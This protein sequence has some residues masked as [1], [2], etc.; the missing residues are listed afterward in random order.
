MSSETIV[1][2][3]TCWPDFT[4]D[5]LIE[6]LKEYEKRDRRFGAIKE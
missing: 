2:T 1:F 3:N 6:C 5:K 4:P